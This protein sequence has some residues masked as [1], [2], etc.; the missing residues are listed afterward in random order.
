MGEKSYMKENER[1]TLVLVDTCAFRDVNSDFPGVIRKL[2]PSFFSTIN[3]KG[4][5][6]LTHPILDNEIRKHIEDSGL[7]K[8]YHALI[9]QLIKNDATLKYFECNNEDLFSK[10]KELD[11]KRKLFE[12]YKEYYR[13]AIHLEYGDP[14]DVFSLYF[15]GMPPFAPSGN[16]KNEFPDAFVFNGAKKYL[17]NHPNDILLVVS[18]DTDW[19][20]AFNGIE[21]TVICPS[22]SDALT[23]ISSIDSILSSEML[24]QIFRGAYD[25][26]LADAKFHVERECFELEDYETFNELEIESVEIETV[27]DSFTP[28][29][30]TRDSILISTNISVKVSGYAEAFDEENS[31]WDSVDREYVYMS[32]VDVDFTDAEASVEC[33][34][35]ISFDF[36][37]PEDTAQVVELKLLNQG[38]ICINCPNAEI[39]EIDDD[40]MALRVLREDKGYPRRN[41]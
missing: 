8:N 37:S 28:L 36:D 27:S 7:Y 30:I 12:T 25:E 19:I 15:N 18:K 9:S 24:A 23:K 40:E 26:I 35:R 6:L 2:L 38:N 14:A 1:I 13:N 10:I 29:K 31:V 11:I 41:K 16:K 22:I 17:E 20:S 39:I 33:E 32:Y 3:E 21:N 5:V 34:I 4:I